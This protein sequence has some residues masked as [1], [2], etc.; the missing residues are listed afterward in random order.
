MEGKREE[1]KEGKIQGRRSKEEKIRRKV[2]KKVRRG[3][4]K[5]WMEQ[6]GKKDTEK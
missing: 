1:G 5:K 4:F 6:Q 3:K 2:R